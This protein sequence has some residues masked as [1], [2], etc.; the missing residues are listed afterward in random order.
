MHSSIR[1]WLL[2]RGATSP[3]VIY[4]GSVDQGNAPTIL[5]VS[6]V[7]GLFV[8]RAALDPVVFAAIAATPVGVA[9]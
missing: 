9:S 2:G 7:D 5:A 6:D 3:R 8:G 4:G 1:A